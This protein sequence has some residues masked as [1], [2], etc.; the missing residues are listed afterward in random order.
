MV[1]RR[2]VVDEKQRWLESER[3]R[4][5][6]ERE[7]E[8]MI[9]K[10]KA[11]KTYLAIKEWAAELSK[12]SRAAVQAELE[13]RAH[14][15]K[16]KA[17]KQKTTAAEMRARA[18]ELAQLRAEAEER[19][20]EAAKQ[21][22]DARVSAV[23]SR[24]A[25]FERTASCATCAGIG[26]ALHDAEAQAL[27]GR[28][29]HQQLEI[30]SREEWEK[31]RRGGRMAAVRSLGEFRGRLQEMRDRKHAEAKTP[32]QRLAAP[33]YVQPARR[34]HKVVV[35]ANL[36]G[37]LS[38]PPCRPPPVAVP[39][40]PETVTHTTCDHGAATA[41]SA[42]SQART[43]RRQP[44][45]GDRMT[46]G[47]GAACTMSTVRAR[48]S[49]AG[50]KLS[51]HQQLMCEQRQAALRPSSAGAALS[52][53]GAAAGAE[54]E[55]ESASPPPPR[56]GERLSE[57][58]E[59]RL[60][61]LRAAAAAASGLPLRAKLAAYDR[62]LAQH[63]P[64]PHERPGKAKQSQRNGQAADVDVHAEGGGRRMNAGQPLQEDGGG[65]D[66]AGPHR[67][68]YATRPFAPWVRRMDMPLQA[69]AHPFHASRSAPRLGDQTTEA[70][71]A[72]LVD[73]RRS[74]GSDHAGQTAALWSNV[75][76]RAPFGPRMVTK[77]W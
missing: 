51:H 40:S 52:S 15:A 36:V 18:E 42:S 34:L 41:A 55:G 29:R 10:R 61:D 67:G 49:S 5:E 47:G 75:P 58:Q 43:R 46:S 8:R 26:G 30:K 1:R 56:L 57:Q 71:L 48:P 25:T 59:A 37:E 70:A 27:R 6:R 68:P 64:S 63:S 65:R 7:L 28:L 38:P 21:D 77:V 72:S 13:R 12:P 17:A 16:Q 23:A 22:E 39:S 60:A 66:D 76:S 19:E 4:M 9:N 44:E 50:G 11:E 3:A 33:K 32:T 53:A 35:R 74:F 73:Q 2:D 62:L 24:R 31:V 14:A 69:N 45:Y 54:L 20:A